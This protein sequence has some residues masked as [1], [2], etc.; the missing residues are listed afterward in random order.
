VPGD[1]EAREQ[2]AA[3]LPVGRLGGPEEVAK[4]VH[5]LVTNPFVTSQS[6]SAGGGTYPR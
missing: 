2:F 6:V 5:A 4:T 3:R 1:E